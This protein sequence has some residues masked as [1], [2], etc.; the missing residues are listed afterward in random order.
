MNREIA[1]LGGGCFWCLEAVFLDVDG[2]LAVE[3]GYAGGHVIDPT[4][5]AVC[6]GGT[7]HAEVVQVEF[8]AD[9]IS[10]RELLEIFF[11]IHDPTTRDRQGNDIGSQY[12]SVIFTHSQQQAAEARA[13]IADLDARRL[14]PAPIVTEVEAISNYSTAEPYHQ[15]YFE[16]HPNQ[17]YCAMIVA[18]KLAKFRKQFAHRLRG[19]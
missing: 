7:G 6:D 3:S 2:V 1:T 14:W 4:Y 13:L 11:A 10:Y 19:R 5:E 17:G 15:R 8:D 18:P 12:R 9:A 16:Q